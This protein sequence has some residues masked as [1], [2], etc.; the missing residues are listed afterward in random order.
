MPL[1]LPGIAGQADAHVRIPEA[2]VA[3]EQ[4]A[5]HRQ[6]DSG[7][8]GHHNAALIQ[9]GRGRIGSGKDLTGHH[10]RQKD[11]AHAQHGVERGQERR[12]QCRAYQREKDALAG[13]RPD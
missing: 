9:D 10:A 5:E 1:R 11:D 12:L 7:A 8:N 3:P 4:G 2:A 6:A 13:A